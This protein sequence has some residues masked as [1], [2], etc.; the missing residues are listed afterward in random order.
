MMLS[1]SIRC[2]SFSLAVS[3]NK[4]RKEGGQWTR[5]HIAGARASKFVPD[6]WLET[7]IVR[8]WA[9][10]R[11]NKGPQQKEYEKKKYW[12]ETTRHTTMHL[13]FFSG[14]KWSRHWTLFFYLIVSSACGSSSTL[15]TRHQW[16]V[17][18]AK[19]FDSLIL[20]FSF[21]MGYNGCVC[22][23]WIWIRNELQVIFCSHW[24]RVRFVELLERRVFAVFGQRS[25]RR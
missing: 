9:M 19:L 1:F 17:E 15:V 11:E 3:L 14:I 6:F 21:G 20:S 18:C 12:K 4:H 5:T 16:L 7:N 22:R 2:V 23:E 24:F 25:C 13:L 8:K 10:E